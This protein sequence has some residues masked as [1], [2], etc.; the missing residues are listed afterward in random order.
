MSEDV[1]EAE[2]YIIR[3]REFVQGF[4]SQGQGRRSGAHGSAGFEQGYFVYA[5]RLS[6]AAGS[7]TIS[8]SDIEERLGAG[9]DAVRDQAV[10]G[11]EVGPAAFG[12]ARED[13]GKTVIG[14]DGIFEW[15][16]FSHGRILVLL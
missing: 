13:G 9:R 3:R 12:D 4:S 15:R 2:D 8:G 16:H 6:D 5:R 11:I 14:L 7:A 10:Y 1:P